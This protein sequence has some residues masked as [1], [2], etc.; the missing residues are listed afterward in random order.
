MMRSIRKDERACSNMQIALK[1]Q[2]SNIILIVFKH[3]TNSVVYEYNE[4]TQEC[5]FVTS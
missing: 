5:G 1:G 3:T 2:T 4:M